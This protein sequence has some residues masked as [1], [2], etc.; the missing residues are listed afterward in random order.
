LYS[1]GSIILF[2]SLYLDGFRIGK[3]ND[4]DENRFCITLFHYKLDIRCENIMEDDVLINFG[5]I[6]S[7]TIFELDH[8]R[9]Q[10]LFNKI[11]DLSMYTD[12]YF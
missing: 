12:L 4:I 11:N 3:I 5:N 6:G 8:K 10:R 1:K 9:Q 2:S 7:K